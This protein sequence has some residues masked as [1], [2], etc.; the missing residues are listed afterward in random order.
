M[1]RRSR[2]KRT[3]A[4]SIRACCSR[5]PTTSRCIA[6]RIADL[7]SRDHRQLRRAIVAGVS[8][9]VA[10]G[11]I[12]RH[13]ESGR[14]SIDEAA[15]GYVRLALALGDRDADSLDSYHGPPAWQAE[16]RREHATL[17]EIRRRG[18]A[19][20]KAVEGG[21]AGPTTDAAARR[22]VPAAAPPAN[23]SPNG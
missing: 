21:R 15:R 14:P 20:P 17:P 10:A 7:R 23:H 4:S 8:A 3:H 1:P 13:A 11:C 19:L 6:W 22:A 18:G 16:V 2:R 9:A 5:S 12:A